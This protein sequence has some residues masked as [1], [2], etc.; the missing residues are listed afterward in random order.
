ML[1]INF[2]LLFRN[3]AQALL[4]EVAVSMYWFTQK[5]WAKGAFLNFC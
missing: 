2:H 5:D 3:S 1:R 4:C